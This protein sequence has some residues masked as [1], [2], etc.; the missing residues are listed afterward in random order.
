[1]VRDIY[2]AKIDFTDGTGSK[3]R[4]ILLIQKNTYGDYIFIPL[5]TNLKAKGILIV[6]EGIEK[7]SLLKK[8]V[9]IIEKIS[10]ISSALLIRKIAQVNEELYTKIIHAICEFIRKNKY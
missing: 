2:L 1:M 5:S 6:D 3:I 8:T 7:G 9:A 10:V 4:P